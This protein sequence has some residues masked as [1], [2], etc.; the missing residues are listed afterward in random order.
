M[1][2]FPL[3]PGE[4]F[5][6]WYHYGPDYLRAVNFTNIRNVTN[7]RN[8]TNITNIENVQY[9][10]RTVATTAV[11]AQAFR[12]AQPVA[13][14]AVKLRPEQLAKAQVI[15]HPSVNPTAR[16]ASPGKPVKAPPV[17]PHP[18]VA[19]AK[20]GPS[21][22]PHPGATP[23]PGVREMPVQRNAARPPA[24]SR[25]ITKKQPPPPPVPFVDMRQAMIKHPGRP[26]EPA[27]IGDLRARRPV[28]PMADREFPAHAFP[29]VRERATA[30]PAR[31]PPRP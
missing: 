27:Q 20:A 7:I 30:P 1:G 25:L 2:W 18:E 31:R 6:P 10:Y 23:T 14:N 12:S 17:R 19:A 21:A 29:G 11:P 9:K 22:R 28:R 13:H 16:A 15:P 4:P 5:L 3:G 24:P 8:I 26:L